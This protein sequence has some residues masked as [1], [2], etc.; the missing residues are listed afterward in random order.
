MIRALSYW[1]APQN[2]R[3][4]LYGVLEDEEAAFIG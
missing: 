3:V 2:T 1:T 4:P